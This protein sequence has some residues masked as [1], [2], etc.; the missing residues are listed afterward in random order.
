MIVENG[1]LKMLILMIFLKTIIYRDVI[2]NANFLGLRILREDLLNKKIKTF[3][4]DFI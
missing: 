2:A 4:I 1:T 3:K